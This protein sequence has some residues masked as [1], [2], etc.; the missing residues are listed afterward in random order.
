MLFV[1]IVNKM[2]CVF[3]ASLEF[4]KDV[5]LDWLD[6]PV[7]YICKKNWV[8]GSGV[9]GFRVWK[10]RGVAC[11][12]LTFCTCH[13]YIYLENINL[14][15]NIWQHTIWWGGGRGRGAACTIRHTCR[16]HCYSAIEYYSFEDNSQKFIFQQ[17]TRQPSWSKKEEN[18]LALS[19]KTRNN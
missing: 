4:T 2:A 14:C 1:L 10:E 16:S 13:I 8:G 5:S 17:M 11:K 12:Y 7:V 19:E 15:I 3:F 9:G 18:R 6:S